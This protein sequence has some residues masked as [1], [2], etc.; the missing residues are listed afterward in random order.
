MFKFNPKFGAIRLIVCPDT[1]RD[2]ASQKQWLMHISLN[3]KSKIVLVDQLFFFIGINL[4]K[5]ANEIGKFFSIY[6]S[7]SNEVQS[8]SLDPKSCRVKLDFLYSQVMFH[9]L[10][11]EPLTFQICFSQTTSLSSIDEKV[12]KKILFLQSL[13]TTK[14]SPQMSQALWIAIIT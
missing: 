4:D 11:S 7:H 14:C 2:F 6:K 9:S 8:M 10:I 12:K 3:S 1:S 13:V 5:S